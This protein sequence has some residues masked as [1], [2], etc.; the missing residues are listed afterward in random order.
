M[1]PL[2]DAPIRFPELTCFTQKK[3]NQGDLVT[4]KDWNGHECQ[5][6]VNVAEFDDRTQ[7][8]QYRLRTLEGVDFRGGEPISGDEISDLKPQ[9]Q[10]PQAGPSTGPDRDRPEPEHGRS[11]QQQQQQAAPHHGPSTGSRPET[12][13]QTDRSGGLAKVKGY[14]KDTIS[15]FRH[16]R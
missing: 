6:K 10:E 3:R 1:F 4:C 15:K 2:Q 5:V 8:M 12:E 16:P 14:L 7:Q 13:P 9:Q 11:Q